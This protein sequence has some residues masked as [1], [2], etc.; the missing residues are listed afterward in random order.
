MMETRNSIAERRERSGGSTSADVLCYFPLHNSIAFGKKKKKL[1]RASFFSWAMV[2]EL[3]A[4][5]PQER[6]SQDDQDI[7]WPACK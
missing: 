3:Q 6:G 7:N 4:Y 5:G 1:V 2:I